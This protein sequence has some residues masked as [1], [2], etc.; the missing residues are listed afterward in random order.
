MSFARNLLL[1]A[2]VILMPHSSDAWQSLVAEICPVLG[3]PTELAMAVIRAE[4]QG[5]PY[6]LGVTIPRADGNGYVHQGYYPQDIWT[7]T[8]LLRQA[9]RY[10]RNVGVG[11]MQITWA[12]DPFAL[13][14]PETNIRRGCTKLA[15]E[16]DGSG[17]LIE[18]IGRYHSRTPR[19]RDNYGRKILSM[20]QFQV[21]DAKTD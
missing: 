9:L 18:R 1:L 14:D 4:S 6:A 15:D 10:T 5:K 8:A 12:D 17:S 2:T 21:A 7:A 3:V 19:L 16:L 11:L 20:V 13:L